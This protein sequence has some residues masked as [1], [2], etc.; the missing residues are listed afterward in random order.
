MGESLIVAIFKTVMLL[1]SDIQEI[2][3]ALNIEETP[4][5]VNAT[6]PVKRKTSTPVKR[7][8]KYCGKSIAHKH[9][10]AKFCNTK[11]KDKYHNKH[12]PRGIY[13]HLSEPRKNNDWAGG[14]NEYA[15]NDWSECD[16]HNK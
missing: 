13:A 15:W 12:N 1:K 16:Y 11:H 5:E 6:V 2:K 7:K 8:C 10:N 9:P 3:Q 4:D 14:E